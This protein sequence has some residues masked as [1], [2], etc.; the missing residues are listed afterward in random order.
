MSSRA[1]FQAP[2]IPS[3]PRARLY[4]CISVWAH[5]KV[6]ENNYEKVVKLPYAD[7]LTSLELPLLSY[8]VIA[9]DEEVR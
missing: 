8:M 6:L 5:S 1:H 7:C 4:L 2:K 9:I 3:V